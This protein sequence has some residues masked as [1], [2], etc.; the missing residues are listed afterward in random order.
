MGGVPHT[1]SICIVWADEIWEVFAG[2]SAGSCNVCLLDLR[3]TGRDSVCHS[4]V[5]LRISVDV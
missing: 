2:F 1:K 5:P 3:L 4:D